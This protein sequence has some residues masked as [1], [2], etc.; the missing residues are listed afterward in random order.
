MKMRRS[1]DHAEHLPQTAFM[2]G[3]GGD[4]EFKFNFEA[5]LL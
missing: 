5:Q 3:F 1:F 4:G 2:Q